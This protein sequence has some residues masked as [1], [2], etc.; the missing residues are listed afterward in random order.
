MGRMVSA[1]A[2]TEAL[3]V[4]WRKRLPEGQ[5]RVRHDDGHIQIEIDG[6]QTVSLRE[7]EFGHLLLRGF[8][9]LARDLLRDRAESPL[10]QELFPEQDF[11]I[12]E[13]DEF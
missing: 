10:L 3:G 2:L 7:A 11:V 8:D 12:W 6:E 4:L 9:G 13:S 1:A 5:V